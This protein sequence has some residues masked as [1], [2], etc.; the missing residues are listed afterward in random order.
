VPPMYSAK[1]IEGKKLYELARKGESVVRDPIKVRVFELER[2]GEPQKDG[3]SLR[4]RV[5]CSAGTYIRTLAEDIGRKLGTGAHLT[6]LRR[7]RAG[8]F[9]LAESITIKELANVDGPLSALHSMEEAVDHLP[10]MML[11]DERM[12]RTKNGLSTRLAAEFADGQAIQMH[13]RT[14][15]LIAVGF[16]E[17]A[18]R[19]VR[20]KI[21]L[22]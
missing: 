16:Y 3:T 12:E 13:S 10:T 18:E 6:E 20:P 22:V 5:I 7:T 4:V 2:S 14:G 1:K 17:A 11:S 19:A 9:K 15:E 8:K 21:V